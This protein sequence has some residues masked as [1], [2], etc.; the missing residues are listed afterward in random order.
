MPPESCVCDRSTFQARRPCNTRRKRSPFAPGRRGWIGRSREGAC[1]SGSQQLPFG[2]QF[3]RA[4]LHRQLRPDIICRHAAFP[5]TPFRLSLRVPVFQHNLRALCPRRQRAL[6]EEKGDCPARHASGLC[7]ATRQRAG[8][9]ISPGTVAVLLSSAGGIGLGLLVVQGETG[10]GR[11][12]PD[13][14]PGQGG[15]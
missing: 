2:L 13:R 14:R 15:V 3:T 9:R 7:Q 4:L 8:G 11:L 1:G 6:Q 10:G 12:V 5:A